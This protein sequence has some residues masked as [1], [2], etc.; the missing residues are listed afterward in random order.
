MKKSLFLPAAIFPYTIL[1]AFVCIYQGTVI[2]AFFNANLFLFLLFF[3]LWWVAA[4]VMTIRQIVRAVRQEDSAAALAKANMILKLIHIPVYVG[5]FLMG[6]ALSVTILFAVIL[7]LV[8]LDLMAIALSG[9]VGCAAVV[10]GQAEGHLT[11]TQAITFG[12]LQF[13]F[14]LDVISAV[15]LWLKL[16]TSSNLNQKFNKS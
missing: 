9:L 3:F 7:L 11:R 16:R 1:L 10:R 8:V 6:L 4:L 12:V 5:I 2:E 15:V 14:C 13:V